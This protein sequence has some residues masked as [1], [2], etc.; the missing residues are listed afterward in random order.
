MTTNK[1]IRFMHNNFLPDGFTY[2]SQ[3]TAFPASN[4]YGGSRSR[5]WRPTGNFEIT[6][7]NN[8]IYINDGSNKTATLTAASYTPAALATHV[9]TQLNAVSTSWTCTYSTTTFKFTIGRSGSGTIRQTQTTNAAWDTLGYTFGTD[10]TG[11]TFTADEQRNH[12]SEWFKCDLG[13]PQVAGFVG[14]IGSIET[15]FSLTESATLKIQANNIDLW[16]A[17]PLNYDIPINGIGAMKFLDDNESSYRYWRILIIDRLNTLGPT[18][19][20]IGY[21]YIG[22]YKTMTN[23]NIQVGF[24][25][26]YRDP[27]NVQESETGVLFIENRPR[28]LTISSAEIA[29]L[30]GTEYDELEQ[31]FYDVGVRTPFFVSLDP[32]LG[33]S[34]AIT[35]L[36]R[37]MIMDDV[38]TM[39][40]VIR[41]YYNISFNMREAF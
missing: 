40:H 9:Q 6:A 5:V 22:D 31:L 16:T 35:D 12:T 41:D 26:S 3:Q 21:A 7:T 29:L 27:S 14:L 1:N 39:Q 18:G 19:I 20:E 32:T 25:K 37:L 11:T 24:S 10:L 34:R 33:V 23:T 30:N 15:P 36:T 28:Y 38:P 13:V 2:S 17:P 4:V 8:L